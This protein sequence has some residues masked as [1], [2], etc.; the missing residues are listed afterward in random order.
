MFSGFSKWV[1]E[2]MKHPKAILV[3]CPPSQSDGR[4]EVRD[5]LWQKFATE[6]GCALVGCYFRDEQPG[7]I[8]DYCH[9]RD[10]AS[11]YLL[12]DYI[13]ENFG[14]TLR[15]KTFPI[16]PPIFLWGFSAGGQ[17]AYEFAV[18]FP[19]MVAG[20]VVNKGGVYYTALAPKPVRDIPALIIIGKRDDQ[21]RQDILRGI[22]GLNRRAGAKWLK[23]EEDTG[24]S[25]GSSREAGVEFFKG[26]LKEL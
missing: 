9:V 16:V 4:N 17:F 21:F 15:D 13:F 14:I 7:W 19:D 12:R 2:G 8:E 6:T 5:A 23:M 1:P 22:W 11:G 20:F 24:H 18:N 10:S 26:L 3:I 25:E